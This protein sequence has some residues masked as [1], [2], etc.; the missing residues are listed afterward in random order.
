MRYINISDSPKM[1]LSK[2]NKKWVE[3]GGSV[4]VNKSDIKHFGYNIRFFRPS[5]EM[6]IPIPG[7]DNKN[8]NE[9][10][11]DKKENIIL[12]TEDVNSKKE[13]E[14]SK[15]TPVYEK[16]EDETKEKSSSVKNENI[17]K[18]SKD[19]NSTKPRKKTNKKDRKPEDGVPAREESI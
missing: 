17:K 9:D 7:N 14:T 4:H 13:E 8:K 3:P 19:D 12:N 18:E 2:M 1:A 11:E 10:F 5:I 6:I 16:K 15:E